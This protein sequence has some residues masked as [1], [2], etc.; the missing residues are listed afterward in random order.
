[1]SK[2]KF[3]LNLERLEGRETPSTV[4]TTVTYV[5]GIPVTHVSYVSS[6]P[7]TTPPTTS[8]TTPPPTTTTPAPPTTTSTTPAQQSHALY[9]SGT[10]TYICT[11]EFMT[12]PSGYHFT[13]N[14]SVKS[15]GAVQMQIDVYGNG[16]NNNGSAH[17]TITLTNA[18]GSVTVQI[19]GPSQPKLSPLP[20]SFQYKIVQATGAYRGM[21]DTGTLQLI[22]TPDAVPVRLGLRF[23]E[24]GS[25]RVI[26]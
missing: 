13:G 16:F 6:P 3:R 17:G 2:K 8:H 9:G 21:T 1:M 18:K 15:M 19:T 24:A 14:G 12:V 7:A 22:R 26:L 10:G 23:F 25:F 11:L 5:A 4:V 20:E